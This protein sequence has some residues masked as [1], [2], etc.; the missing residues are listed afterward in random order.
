[1]PR[2]DNEFLHKDACV[3]EQYLALQTRKG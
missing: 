1:L 3:V 2:L